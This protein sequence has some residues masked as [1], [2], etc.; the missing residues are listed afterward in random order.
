MLA[1]NAQTQGYEITLQSG[2]EGMDG[3][4]TRL[5]TVWDGALLAQAEVQALTVL[6]IE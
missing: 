1:T 3:K 5:T 2:D 6:S 4:I